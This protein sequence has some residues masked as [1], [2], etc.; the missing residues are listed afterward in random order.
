MLAA[1][2]RGVV[3]SLL[4]LLIAAWV[5]AMLARAARAAWSQRRL[6]LTVWGRVRVRHLLGSLGLLAVVLAV[7]VTLLEMV[8]VT[9]FGLGTLIDTGGNAVFTPLL[10]AARRSPA[11]GSGG[12][13]WLL[14]GGA[15]V[16]L[17]LLAAVLPWLA[18]VE[19]EMFRAGLEI[20]S[21][22]REVGVALV[23]G[24]AHLVMLVP[25]AAAL[26]IAVAGLAYGRIYRRAHRRADGG[27]LPP[28]VAAAFRPTR[29]SARA[30]EQ[31]RSRHAAPGTP[32]PAPSAPVV[33]RTPERR[34]AAAVLAS[35]VWHTTFNTIVVVLVWAGVTVA[36][37]RPA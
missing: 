10:E 32:V 34:Q 17:G 11:T 19:E 14:A 8:P 4:R 16:F 25:V 5:L 33:D 2:A 1:Y 7:S 3:S 37:L 12:P 18:F 30:A 9:R 6:V 28:P 13:D 21:P 24:A 27:P 36:A 31:A 29:R 15:S 26:A 23:F 22:A 20:A 35:T